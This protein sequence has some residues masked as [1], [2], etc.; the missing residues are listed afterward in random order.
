M[1]VMPG[2]GGRFF[3]DF[4][5]GDIYEHRLGRTITTVDNQWFTLLTLNTNPLHFDHVYSAQTGFGKPLVN[6]AFTLA[7]ITGM[8]VEDISENAVANLGWDDIKLVH[9]VYEGDTLYA[10]S[11]IL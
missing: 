10:K 8:S 7:L 9:P 11:E 5:A 4:S 1:P 2:Y 6:S 3:L